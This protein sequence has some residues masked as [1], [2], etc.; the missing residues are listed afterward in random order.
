MDKLNYKKSCF[1]GVEAVNASTSFADIA[2]VVHTL[3]LALP[4]TDR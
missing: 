2:F 4:A 3:F 1:K